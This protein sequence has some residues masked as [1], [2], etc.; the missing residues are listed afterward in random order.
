[1][2][3]IH[4]NVIFK[5]K[6]RGREELYFY[7]LLNVRPTEYICSYEKELFKNIAWEQ[8]LKVSHAN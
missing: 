3:Q 1:M 4:T 8:I 2:K 7:I 5:I 6:C